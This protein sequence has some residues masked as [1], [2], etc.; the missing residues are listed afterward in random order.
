MP[1]IFINVYNPQMLKAGTPV[2][3]LFLSYLVGL[4]KPSC[5]EFA[6]IVLIALGVSITSVGE[7][8]FS[9]IGINSTPFFRF[10][11]MLLVKDGI[12]VLMLIY[13]Y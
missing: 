9:L 6:I 11:F 12:E 5:T 3:V 7:L 1:M 10:N 2:V 13:A 4:E 8:E